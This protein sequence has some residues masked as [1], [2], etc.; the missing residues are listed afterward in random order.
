MGGIILETADDR[1]FL[2]MKRRESFQADK[3][4]KLPT[5]LQ[6]GVS[7]RSRSQTIVIRQK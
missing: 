7:N 3:S 4:K 5:A 2:P 6:G 1:L